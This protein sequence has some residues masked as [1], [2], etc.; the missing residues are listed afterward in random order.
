MLMRLLLLGAFIMALIG[1]WDRPEGDAGGELA[2]ARLVFVIATKYRERSQ[3]RYSN[4]VSGGT[5][6]SQLH[7]SQVVQS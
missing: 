4:G 5:G 7:L 2:I 3:V 1:L 6:I